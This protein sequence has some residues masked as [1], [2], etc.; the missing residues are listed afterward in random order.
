MA[1]AG[2]TI[3]GNN[4]DPPAPGIIANFVSTKPI[5]EFEEAILIS[6]ARAISRPPP[7]NFSLKNYLNKQRYLPTATPS[8]ATKTGILKL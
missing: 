4:C 1:I 2:P 6:E 5:L 3:L 8:I 7:T